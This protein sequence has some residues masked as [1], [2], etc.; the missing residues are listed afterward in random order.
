MNLRTVEDDSELEMSDEAAAVDQ[1]V[2]V[3]IALRH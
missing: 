2:Y 1:K 3:C